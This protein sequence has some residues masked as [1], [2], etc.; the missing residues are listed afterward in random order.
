MGIFDRLKDSAEG[1]V[2]AAKDKVSD[3]TGV[4]TD[5]LIDAASSVADAGESLAN[6]RDSLAEGQLDR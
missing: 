2:E 3:V 4:D 5:K 6:A 1:L